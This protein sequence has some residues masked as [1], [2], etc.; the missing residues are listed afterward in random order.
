M[1]KILLLPV[2]SILLFCAPVFAD[3][4]KGANAVLK[5]DYATALKEFKPNA[6][7][8]DAYAQYSLGYIYS[9]GLGVTQ[10]YKTA[11]KWYTLE[12]EFFYKNYA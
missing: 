8:G 9:N 6:E 10:D 12:N 1:K 4:V 2:I 7:K 11:V 5:E 3:L